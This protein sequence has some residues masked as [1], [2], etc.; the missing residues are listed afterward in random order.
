MLSRIGLSSRILLLGALIAVC[1][2]AVLLVWM[3][4][5][6]REQGYG[7]RTEATRHIVE[8]AVGILDYYGQ[9]AQSGAMPLAAA[10]A[11]A[12]N[13][14]QHARYDQTNYV[15]I[16][17]LSPKMIMHPSKPQMNGK[18][19]SNY[20]DPNGVLLFVEGVRLARA[21]GGGVI[22]YVWA[23]PGSSQPLPKVS[24][25]KLYAPWGWVVGS[26]VWVDDI[27]A[28]FN[29]LRNLALLVTLLLFAVTLVL[30]YR[31]AL[32]ISVPIRQAAGSLLRCTGET[33]ASVAQI[34]SGAHSSA[35]GFSK[36]AASL[37]EAS[38]SL[39]DL[40]VQIAQNTR[41][42]A[43]MRQLV[44]E[45][46][47]LLAGGSSLVD[48]MNGAIAHIMQ[49]ARE[50]QKIVKTIEGIA[51]QTNILALNAAVEAAHAGAA[52]TG[53]SVVAAE[54][55]L[56][57]QRSTGAAHET[58]TLI[59]HSLESSALGSE[60]GARLTSSFSGIVEK[61]QKLSRG[62]EHFGDS[63]RNQSESLGQINAAVSQISQLTQTH[64]ATSEEIDSATQDLRDQTETS[65]AMAD[66]L[67]HI[68]EPAKV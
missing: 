28:N 54:V 31:M 37:E 59:L 17:D 41:G 45:V 67:F 14:L 1:F 57:A 43:D 60:I 27:E 4:P 6:V 61:A 21:H 13:A 65:R 58:S 48:D 26:G 7:M 53:F 55:R 30:C 68:V 15:W 33:S 22:H 50:V 44:R 46:T 52:G 16:N 36:Q 39:G 40:T 38:A 23:K 63:F 64:A 34:A 2:P 47:D 5:R 25:V 20:R 51:F 9:Q 11:A 10:Q 18:D 66:S 32:S 35:I 19:L 56:L 62:L 42:A 49:S 8:S 12:K 29:Q 3:L 24:Y